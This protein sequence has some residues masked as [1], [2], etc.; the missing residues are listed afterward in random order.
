MSSAPSQA[1]AG[2]QERTEPRPF[3]LVVYGA[4]GFTG[5]LVVAALARRA[6]STLRWA[7]AGRDQARLVAVRDA[8]APGAA[9]VVADA[10]D[11]GALRALAQRSRVILTTVGPYARHGTPLLAA[12]AAAGTDYADLTGEPL[13]MRASIDAFHHVAAASGARLVHAC[14]F[15]SV[16]SDLG[17][18]ALQRAALERHGRP[19]DSVVHLIER[20]RGG[21]SGG[22]VA[23]GLDLLEQVARSPCARRALADPDLLA[24]GAAPSVDAVGPWWPQ[25]H[26]GAE[27]WSLPFVMAATNAK[28]VRRSRH[29]LGEPWGAGVHYRERLTASTWAR[30][31]A[32]GALTLSVAAL[33][34]F[35]PLRALARRMLPA[36][37]SGPSRAVREGGSFR[38]RLLGTVEGVA[39]PLVVR[40]EGDADPGY[41]ATA[42][43]LAEVGLGLASGEF[44]A[45]GGAAGDG[46]RVPAGVTTP[47]VVGGLL[48]IERLT[49]VGVRVSVEPPQRAS[50]R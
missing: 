18:L 9:V 38:T 5:R 29:L 14:G 6:P 23:S 7:V 42:R 47:A 33:L 10:A 21:V 48:L 43:M 34:S 19:C 44:D 49:E 3:D 25:R 2:H 20:M 11:E 1:A 32:L 24:P 4:S 16:P 12:C 22:T 27:G 37:G 46:R 17:V 50:K 26:R 41:E 45:V 39:E 13:W 36:S 30:A 35:A 31:A 40:I 8:L 15:D 28:V